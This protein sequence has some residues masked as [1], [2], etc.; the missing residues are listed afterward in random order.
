MLRKG[1]EV[2]ESVCNGIQPQHWH[3]LK[4]YKNYNITI[5]CEDYEP[6]LDRTKDQVQLTIYNENQAETFREYQKLFLVKNDET[7]KYFL[8]Y[9]NMG[10]AQHKI[11]YIF[12]QNYMTKDKF[13]RVAEQ[14]MYANDFSVT[15]DSCFTS[16][17]VNGRCPYSYGRYIDITFDGTVRSCPYA[18]EG[19]HLPDGLFQMNYSDWEK[20]MDQIFDRTE[21]QLENCIHLELFGGLLDV[22][23]QCTSIPDNSSDN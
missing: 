10:Y 14:K 21:T 4:F 19:E 17:M 2:Y 16:F 11:H 3:L 1:W 12:E 8:K 5:S 7:W 20:E 13:R 9:S 15:V 23:K 18:L 22:G 6:Y